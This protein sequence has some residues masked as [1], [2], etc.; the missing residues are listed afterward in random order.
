MCIEHES[1]ML[2][3]KYIDINK[4][5]DKNSKNTDELEFLKYL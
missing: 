1:L 3:G 2:N 4:A 5:Y